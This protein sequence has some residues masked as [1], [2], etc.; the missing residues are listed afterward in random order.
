ML[1]YLFVAFCCFTLGCSTLQG[2]FV[3]DAADKDAKVEWKKDMKFSVNGAVY[4]GVAVVDHADEYV[5]KV[6]PSYQKIDRIQWRTCHQDGHADKA[7]VHGFWPWSSKDEFFT[8]KVRASHIERDRA[9]PLEIESLTAQNKSMSFGIII[10]D[11]L[12]PWVDLSATLECNGKLGLYSRG[13]S[14]CQAP[15]NSVQRIAVDTEAIQDDRPN[16]NCPPMKQ[17]APGV[18]E[19]FM[20]KGKCVY[21][22]KVPRRHESGEWLTHN[23]ITYGYER[24]PPAEK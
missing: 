16:D 4:Y 11:D 3:P 12:R 20:P 17:A 23:L 1:K 5:I 2:F 13:Q 8:M 22:F 9:C 21:V 10:F 24:I 19:Y 14:A 6:Y 15:V 18:F 7:V